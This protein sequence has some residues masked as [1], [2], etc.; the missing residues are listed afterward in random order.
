MAKWAAAA[1]LDGGTDVLRT[2]AATAGR[3]KMH[4][5]K[6]YS[7]GD[8][9]ATVAG[10]SCGSFDMAAADFAQGANGSGR[11][12]TV[13]GKTITLT[14]NSGATPDLHIAIVD[15]AG[16]VVLFVTDETSNQVLTS[17]NTFAVPAWTIDA[18]QPT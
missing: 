11:R 6:A 17:G 10:N 12:T 15:S 3:V 7:T 18:G 4:V 8:S 1:V 2:L 13:A 5:V 9:Y 14:A 16:S